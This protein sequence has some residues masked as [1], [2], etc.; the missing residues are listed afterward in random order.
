[1]AQGNFKGMRDLVRSGGW[2]MPMKRHGNVWKKVGV[3]ELL[4]KGFFPC[5]LHLTSTQMPNLYDYF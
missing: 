5:L 2:E 1:M 4:F 3:R